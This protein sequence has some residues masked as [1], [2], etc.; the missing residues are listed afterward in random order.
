MA[1]TASAGVVTGKPPIESDR[2]EGTAVYD[3]KGNKIGSVKRLMI[4][5][6]GQDPGAEIPP[7]LMRRVSSADFQRNFS[8]LSAH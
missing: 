7:S 2:V 6:N 8:A 4:D 1:A 3:R 5:R